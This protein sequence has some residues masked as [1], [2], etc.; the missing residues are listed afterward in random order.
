MCASFKGEFSHAIDA[1]GR[2]II[3]AKFRE[4]LG[5]HFVVTKGFDGCL[6]V[7]DQEGWDALEQ[8]LAALPLNNKDAR[9]IKRFFLAGATDPELDKQGRSL[10]PSPLLQ[11]AGITKDVT[12]VGVG[13]KLEIWSSDRWS[14]NEESM[15][16]I[17][18]LASDLGFEF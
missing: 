8:K 9:L 5:D 7:F 3:P 11:H 13:D 18:D 1:K 17:D 10:I 14:S 6:Y 4:G 16:K 15:E 12:V 2:L